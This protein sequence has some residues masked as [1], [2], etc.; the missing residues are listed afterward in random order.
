MQGDLTHFKAQNVQL[1]Q[2]VKFIMVGYLSV[3]LADQFKI[4]I[5]I[6]QTLGEVA[7]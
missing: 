2:W 7:W 4:Q 6:P 3:Q 5:Y 1:V